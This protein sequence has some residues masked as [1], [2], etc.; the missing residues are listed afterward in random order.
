MKKNINKF[1]NKFGFEIKKAQKQYITTQFDSVN[2]DR[3]LHFHNLINLTN[4]VK[5]EIVECGVG[6]GRSLASISLLVKSLRDERSIW[7]FDSF[8]GFPEPTE[9]DLSVD[10]KP[11]KGEYSVSLESVTEYLNATLNDESFMRS[12]V[13][14]VKGFFED[15]LLKYPHENISLLNLDVDIYESYKK[16]L[17]TFYP[18]LSIGGI[19][20]FDE[21]LREENRFPGAYKAIEEYFSNKNVI[22][23][24]S[25]FYG[26]YYI[27]K[28]A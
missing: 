1:L 2:A 26:K 5:G 11:A 14:L 10:R 6:M 27:I 23:N 24:R 12:R 18:K 15:T 9:I 7:G 13:T 28:T 8:E 25:P 17:E 21:F 22:F 19:I 4:G 20:T 16:C 3:F